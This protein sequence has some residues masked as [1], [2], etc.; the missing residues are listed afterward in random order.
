MDICI[1]GSC[2]RLGMLGGEMCGTGRMTHGN[3]GA[4]LPP[5]PGAPASLCT[6]MCITR[7]LAQPSGR[8]DPGPV[9]LREATGLSDWFPPASPV[10]DELF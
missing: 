2:Q 10:T 7:L 6:P 9:R 8:P 4:V 5:Q 1:F 3:W